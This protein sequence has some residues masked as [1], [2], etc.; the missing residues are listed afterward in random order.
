M[1]Q[2]EMEMLREAIAQMVSRKHGFAASP[3]DKA[4]Q[5]QRGADVRGGMHDERI[6]GMDPDTVFGS[7]RAMGGGITRDSIGQLLQQMEAQGS[8]QGVP[9]DIDQM[10][11]NRRLL[12]E[13]LGR[14]Q[15]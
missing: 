15:G 4:G 3:E 13:I 1:Q 8:A 12:D 6:Q 14:S 9:T 7:G 2:Q 11:Q 5:L 10:E